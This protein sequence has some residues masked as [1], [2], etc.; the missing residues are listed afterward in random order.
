MATAFNLTAQLNVRGPTNVRSIVSSIRRQLGSISANID[1]RVD[2]AAS[3]NLTQISTALTNFN[4]TLRTTQTNAAA[5]AN[6]LRGLSNAISGINA[7]NLPRN[8]TNIATASNRAAQATGRMTAQVGQ[9]RNQMEEFGRQSAIAVRRFAAFSISSGIILGF[10]NAI[11]KG[12]RA[13]I[14]FD[15]EL[16][17][18]QQVTGESANGLSGLQ[19][20]IAGLASGLGVSSSEL[21]NV[22]STLAQAG[23]SARD[24]E[25]ALRALALSALAPSF[26][27]MNKTV[28]GSIALMKQFGISAGELDQALGSVNAVAAKFAVESSDI[29]AAIQRTGGVFASASKGVSEG[30]QALNE[31][32]AVFT[33]I[34]ATT[35][36]SA[37]TIATGLRTIFTRIQ[38]GDTIEALK[39]YGVNLTDVEGKFVGA[40]KAVELLSRGLNNI[41]PRD[42]KFSQIIEQLGGFRQIGKVIPLIQQFGTAQQ[43]LAVAQKGQGSLAED[44]AIAQLSLA[45]QISKVREEFL[46]LIRDIGGTDTFKTI[47]TS[48]LG[49][50]S[51]L[52][53][54]A[55][56]VKGVLPILGVV[57]AIKGASAISSYARGFAGGVGGG[58]GQGRGRRAAKG[59]YIQYAE[60]GG[61]PVALMP[62][63]AVVYP[64]A[65]KKIGT[66]TLRKMN[67]ADK[68][69]AK[70]GNVGVVPGSGNTDSFYTSLPAGSFVIRKKATE[71][72]GVGAINNIASGRQKFIDGETVKKLPGRGRRKPKRGP[73]E[74]SQFRA[75]PRLA[76]AGKT[77]RAHVS[78]PSALTDGSKA[79]ISNFYAHIQKAIPK[80]FQSLFNGSGGT[81]RG[82][83]IENLTLGLPKK[84]N[85]ALKRGSLTVIPLRDFLKSLDSPSLLSAVGTKLS[86]RQKKQSLPSLSGDDQQQLVKLLKREAISSST[87][88]IAPVDYLPKH[89]RVIAS[90]SQL[91]GFT[92]I[93]KDFYKSKNIS[94]NR[95]IELMNSAEKSKKK[96][97]SRGKNTGVVSSGKRSQERDFLPN[98]L[99]ENPN[100]RRFAGVEARL[101]GP[102]QKFEYGGG[103]QSFKSGTSKPIKKKRIAQQRDKDGRTREEYYANQVSRSPSKKKMTNREL[104]AREAYYANQ[105][106][107]SPSK[108]KMTNRELVAREA[109]YAKQVPGSSS[110][111]KMTNRE[112]V[113]RE[114]YYANQATRRNRLAIGGEV[115][116]Q[117]LG[118]GSGRPLSNRK[119]SNKIGRIIANLDVDQLRQSERARKAMVKSG[120]YDPK[121]DT[122]DV[123]GYRDSLAN[124][125][126]EQRKKGGVDGVDEIAAVLGSPGAGKSTLGLKGIGSKKYI[127]TAED[128]QEMIASEKRVVVRNAMA[129]LDEDKVRHLSEYDRIHMLSSTTPA[130]MKE[131]KGRLKNRT[132]QGEESVSATGIDTSTQ[133]GRKHTI[134]AQSSEDTEA[135]LRFKDEK[136][137][138]IIDERKI[139]THSIATGRR[140]GPDEV[141]TVER[142]PV[143]LVKGA[144]APPTL[145][146]HGNLF[147][148][149]DP[150]KSLLV[151]V[152]PD[153]SITEEDRQSILSGRSDAHGARS[154]LM[155]RKT[156]SKMVEK[157]IRDQGINGHV[158]TSGD[159]FVLPSMFKTGKGRYVQPDTK[160]SV[161]VIGEDR[162]ESADK[163]KQKGYKVDVVPRP[164]GGES[165]TAARARLAKGDFN[166]L[167]PSVQK[168]LMEAQQ[169][170]VFGNTQEIIPKVIQQVEKKAQIKIAA[171]DQELNKLLASVPGGRLTKDFKEKNPEATKE[172]E[173][174]R[175]RKTDTKSW[176]K[177]SGLHAL[178]GKLKRRYPERYR[179]NGDDEP[180]LMQ[181]MAD[182]GTIKP[183][184]PVTGKKLQ[185]AAIGGLVQ[186]FIKGTKNPL[187]S[188]TKKTSK[189]STK[190]PPVSVEKMGRADL[191]KKAKELG[192]YIPPFD[193][194]KLDDRAKGSAPV[195]A[196]VIA[197]LK[198]A[199]L[200]ADAK[201]DRVSQLAKNRNIAVVGLTGDKAPEE[202][203][204][205]P[206]LKGKKGKKGIR[207]F[208]ATLQTGALPDD[209]SK[210]VKAIIRNRSER[211]AVRIGNLIAARAGSSPV[212]D[213][214]KIRGIVNKQMEVMYGLFF[215]SGVAIAGAPYDPSSKAI[216]FRDGLGK[217][218][219][220][221]FGVDPKAMT[222]AT[223]Q[224]TKEVSKAKVAKG[225]FTRGGRDVRAKAKAKKLSRSKAALGGFIG[226]GKGGLAFTD[227]DMTA[228]VSKQKETPSLSGFKNPSLAVPDI[229]NA[230]PTGLL[231]LLREQ[232][233]G[234]GVLT[235]RSGGP[236]G[237]MKKALQTFFKQ[238][239]IMVP[240]NRLI[241]LG[242]QIEDVPT[243][244]KK[245]RELHRLVKKYGRFDYFDDREDIVGAAKEVKGVNARRIKVKRASGGSIPSPMNSS[246]SLNRSSKDKR[247]D[248]K[249]L[250]AFL[251]AKTSTSNKQK[252]IA[253]QL[254]DPNSSVS[255][256]PNYEEL[257]KN[258][259]GHAKGGEIPVVA[260]EGEYI[261]NRKS[262]R[263]IGYNNLHGLNKYH[264]GG[265][266]Q[267][268]GKGS[269]TPIKPAPL[270]DQGMGENRI[271]IA[272]QLMS[273]GMSAAKALAQATKMVESMGQAAKQNAENLK[274]QSK[275]VG[276]RGMNVLSGRGVD[277][278]TDGALDPAKEQ[279]YREKNR[280]SRFMR[281][282][283]RTRL[284]PESVDP[285]FV[286]PRLKGGA[287]T[288]TYSKTPSFLDKTRDEVRNREGAALRPVVNSQLADDRSSLKDTM[289]AKRDRIMAKLQDRYKS[290]STTEEKEK[291]QNRANKLPGQANR[292]L[293][294]AD[295]SLIAESQ[296]NYIQQVNDRMK[297][298][299]KAAS[300]DHIARV[301]IAKFAKQSATI[302]E[303]Q[304]TLFQKITQG[305]GKMAASAQKSLGFGGGASGGGGGG[306]IPPSGGGGGRT[307]SSKGKGKGNR[308]GPSGG[309]DNNGR[310]MGM[311]RLTQA[312]FGI[313]MMGGL[314]SQFFNPESSASN[315][316]NAA[317]TE[318]FTSTIGM[319][320]TVAGSV[321]DLMGGGGGDS[322]GRGNRRGNRGGRRNSGSRVPPV[323]GDRPS[324]RAATR[325]PSGGGGRPSKAPSGGGGGGMG[326]LGTA[327]GVLAG[328]AVFALAVAEGLKAAHNAA[329]EFAINLANTKLGESL[330]KANKAVD[331]FRN[332][333]KDKAVASD[334]KG[335]TLSAVKA[336]DTL[337]A[338]SS[339]PEAGL[340]NL[341]D[342]MSGNPG[343]FE[344]S[345]ILN[346]KG[347]VDYLST[348]SMFA[349]GE[350][351]AARNQSAQF[352]TLIPQISSERAKGYTGAAETS[353]A[354]LEAKF[355]SGSTI[356]GMQ[357]DA[358]NPD[359]FN[360]LTKS[361]ALADAAVQQQIMTVQNS[362]TLRQDEKTK[363]KNSIIAINAERKAR[364]IQTKVIRE[365]AIESLNK[366]TTMLQNSL[367]RMFQNMEQAIVSNA[368]ALDKLSA[369]A[370]LASS[371]LSGSAKV[372]SVK[373][374]SINALQNPRANSGEPMNSAVNQAAS[375][376]GNEAPAMKSMLKVASSME[377]AVMSA[378]NNTLKNNPG[379]TNEF[380]GGSIDKSIFKALS[381]L[382]LP[383]DLSAKL[384]GEV[385]LAMKE[386]RKSGED[387]VDF[388]QLVEKIPQLG[389]VLD[390]AKRAQEVAIKSLEN[391]QN[392]LNDYANTTNQLIDIQIDSNQKLRRA[393]DILVS[394]QNELANSLGKSVSLQSV[395]N[396]SRA[397]TASQTG[398][399]TDPADIRRNIQGLEATRQSEQ[400]RSDTAAQR[401]F[402]GKDEFIMMQNRL[403]NTSVALRE[404]YDA[405]KNMAENTDVASAALNKISEIKQQRQAGVGFAEKLVSST[406]KELA[407]L[408]MSMA[409]LQNNMAGGMNASNAG[410]RA[411]DL[412][413]FNELAPLLGDKQSGMKA[414]VLESMLKE[415]GVGVSPMMQDVLDS[416]RNPEGDPAM[417][418]AIGIY[419]EAV[420]L[421]AEANK[422]LVRLNNQMAE[423]SADIAGQKLAKSMTGVILKFESQQLLDINANITTLI[424]AVKAKG[425]LVPGAAPGA[426]PAKGIARGGMIYAAAGQLVDFAPKGTDT[427]PAMLTPGEF[428]VNRKSTQ[429]HLPLLKS[430]NNSKTY[431]KGGKAGY[432]AT[433]GLVFAAPWQREDKEDALD[434]SNSQ[435]NET[436]DRYPDL[437]KDGRTKGDLSG[438]FEK[439][440]S[441]EGSF[442]ATNKN[443]G[444]VT[445]WFFN[446]FNGSYTGLDPQATLGSSYGKLTAAVGGGRSNNVKTSEKNGPVDTPLIGTI[447]HLAFFSAVA[448]E[449]EQV[450]I[451]STDI[452]DYNT[453]LDVLLP[454][455]PATDISGDGV[456]VEGKNIIL[457]SILDPKSRP[458]LSPTVKVTG[459]ADRY[460]K[461]KQ[462]ITI[463]NLNKKTSNLHGLYS[464][465]NLDTIKANSNDAGGIGNIYGVQQDLSDTAMLL[466]TVGDFFFGMPTSLRVMKTSPNMLGGAQQGDQS[467][468]I[469]AGL[470]YMQN[471][472]GFY[473]I[474]LDSDL[475]STTRNYGAG[476][477]GADIENMKLRLDKTKH[478]KETLEKAKQDMSGQDVKFEESATSVGNRNY[479][480]KLQQLLN[481]SV[482]KA[483]FSEDEIQGKDPAKPPVTLY[484]LGGP[485][486]DTR[487]DTLNNNPAVPKGTYA[488]K[489][490]GPS[491]IGVGS[492]TT[493]GGHTQFKAD[494]Y[495]PWVSS[496]FNSTI[497]D[498]LKQK[499]EAQNQNNIKVTPGSYTDDN[500]AFNYNQIE[501]SMFDA[502]KKKTKDKYSFTT[503]SLGDNLLNEK[504]NPFQDLVSQKML[505][506]AP[507]KTHIY[508]D[509][510]QAIID[511]LN[512]SMAQIINGGNTL[513][514]GTSI[515]ALD[516]A[517]PAISKLDFN[518][519]TKHNAYLANSRAPG[520]QYEAK[521][522]G[523]E[524]RKKIAAKKADKDGIAGE[525]GIPNKAKIL[526]LSE[527]PLLLVKQAQDVISKVIAP[528]ANTL[529]GY[530]IRL[531]PI[532]TAEQISPYGNYLLK[533][534]KFFGNSVNQK[535]KNK[536]RKNGQLD[537]PPALWNV[538][539]A[540]G[541]TGQVFEKLGKGDKQGLE[542]LLGSA[543]GVFGNNDLAKLTRSYAYL[544]ASKGS[545]FA[546]TDQSLR[547]EITGDNDKQTI[548]DIFKKKTTE[549]AMVTKGGNLTVNKNDGRNLPTTL[550]DLGKKIVNPYST[551]EPA[552]RGALFD[553]LIQ[554]LN[555]FNNKGQQYSVND[556]LSD[557]LA[558]LK[559]FYGS[560]LDPIVTGGVV[561]T[562]KMT[563]EISQQYEN[564][565]TTLQELTN[566][567]FGMMPD[568]NKMVELAAAKKARM[569]AENKSRGGVIYAQNGTLVD[570]QP[571]GTDTVPAMLTPGEFVV[572]KASTAKHLPL[573]QSINRNSGGMA[574]LAEG[575]VATTS[576][577]APKSQKIPTS[578]KETTGYMSTLALAAEKLVTRSVAALQSASES[579]DAYLFNNNIGKAIQYAVPAIKEGALQAESALYGMA[580]SIV[581]TAVGVGV[582]AV[583][584]P[585]VTPVGG[586]AAGL[587]AGIASSAAQ[588]NYLN[589]LFPEINAYMNRRM[590]DRPIA[591]IAGAAIGG[592]TTR[593]ATNVSKSITPIL[594]GTFSETVANRAAE[595]VK[596]I[597]QLGKGT[598]PERA[599]GAATAAGGSVAVD[600]ASVSWSGDQIDFGDVLTRAARE[601]VVGSLIPAN[602]PVTMGRTS[603]T[604]GASMTQEQ[605]AYLGQKLSGQQLLT[606]VSKKMSRPEGSTY[607]PKTATLNEV[608]AAAQTKAAAMKKAIEP[609]GTGKIRPELPPPPKPLS[610][611]SKPLSPL[612]GTTQ[613]WIS[614][615]NT[616]VASLGSVAP[617]TT[618]L[619]RIGS[620]PKDYVPPK[621]ANLFGEQMPLAE[622]KKKMAVMSQQ[623][624]G[625]DAGEAAGKWFTD[626]HKELD[627]YIKENNDKL[628]TLDAYY[629]DVLTK[630]LH[631]FS[632]SPTGGMK[633][634]GLLS[635]NSEREFVLPQADQATNIGNLVRS[636]GLDPDPTIFKKIPDKR[637]AKTVSLFHA[638]NTGFEDSALKSFQTE[639]GKSGIAEG[640]GQGKGLYNF[641]SR[642]AA[643]KHAQSIMR[644]DVQTRADTRGKPMIVKFDEALDPSKFDLDYELNAG[645]VTKWLYDHYDDVQKILSDQKTPMLLQRRMDP[646]AID[647]EAQKGIRTSVPDGLEQTATGLPPR[648]WIYGSQKD[649]ST[650]DGEILSKIMSAVGK[651]DPKLLS[652]F[653]EGFFETMPPGS[654]I[655]YIG[656]D[657]LAPSNIDVLSKARGG[658]IYASQGARGYQQG[659]VVYAQDGKK[660]DRASSIIANEPKALK[661]YLS[662]K[663]KQLGIPSDIESVVNY[664]RKYNMKELER[665]AKKYPDIQKELNNRSFAQS[666]AQSSPFQTGGMIYASEGKLINFQPRG[667]DTVPAMLTPGEF[668]VNKASTQKNLPLLKAINNGAKN[669]KALSKGGIAYL[670]DGGFADLK[671]GFADLGAYT[672]ND[673][674]IEQGKAYALEIANHAK[675]TAEGKAKSQKC[676]DELG[677]KEKDKTSNRLKFMNS[678]EY[679]SSVSEAKQANT[680]ALSRRNALSIEIAKLQADF[681][682][683][684]KTDLAKVKEQTGLK[685]NEQVFAQF[686]R[687]AIENEFTKPKGNIWSNIEFNGDDL[688]AF[689]DRIAQLVNR[690]ISY[691]QDSVIKENDGA[692]YRN[693]F[694]IKPAL[695][696]NVG[697]R[698]FDAPA[699]AGPFERRD[700]PIVRGL[701]SRTKREM[702]EAGNACR[703]KHETQIPWELKQ[704][705]GNKIAASTL[706]RGGMIYASQGTLVNYQPRGTDTVPA[707]L[708]PGEFVINKQ[709]TQR[710]LPLLKSI[711]S[712]RYQNGGIIQPQYHA[713]GDVSSRM[714]K[715]A[716]AVAGVVGIKLDTGKIEEQIN[717][718]M[719][720]GA[721]LLAGAIGFS[722]SDLSALTAFG[723]SLQTFLSQMSQINIPPEIK[724]SMAPVQVNITGAQG[725]T[726]AAQGLVDGAIKKAFDGF[727]SVNNLQGTYKSP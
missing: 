243:P 417:Q 652:K 54:V 157:T 609:V 413:L 484:N 57:M 692:Y 489:E 523:D 635:A 534:Q 66:P 120:F 219:G 204:V 359:E 218:L 140:K 633:K 356:E 694:D 86:S 272:K 228:A 547:K 196:R 432:Y 195:R 165:G 274:K 574:Y 74:E 662:L 713:D 293:A 125:A 560:Y 438:Y 347:M 115:E 370:D 146:G 173:K 35:R 70:G 411:G 37:E 280:D 569:E 361:L 708:T 508:A 168:M 107:R 573:L 522:Y 181:Q 509:N 98:D 42:L 524:L 502:N 267:K 299:V 666:S 499:Y 495:F 318:S 340:L 357:K 184:R 31:F 210:K 114:A 518:D 676:K 617:D 538:W 44:A 619:Y 527:N 697:D 403:K 177:R 111:K 375:M 670:Q 515:K 390:S 533:A 458:D 193:R 551:F 589:Y 257:L 273:Q 314:G 469:V 482:F 50:A 430:I 13:F 106:S 422:Q 472:G 232:Y 412:Q 593:A 321:G 584:S 244:E 4:T 727:L 603:I 237:E 225:Q 496:G 242:D 536:K 602:S 604:S 710:N 557:K 118:G 404:N 610:N 717:S 315:A 152:G 678:D 463:S 236:K 563:N 396:D 222:D 654:A 553:I 51:A 230:S 30:T 245:A 284:A 103:V 166:G 688:P 49:L 511:N 258:L 354:F 381:D 483:T 262:A 716:G 383:P 344:R 552:D 211:I 414:N 73:A 302:A 142:K 171:I 464:Q 3:R 353:T 160:N 176:A 81:R 55:D 255:G 72:M 639:G 156:R 47:A 85:E 90:D 568:A 452:K 493:V 530:N 309:E 100:L 149:G 418:E 658:M 525:K 408:N 212:T 701:R 660:I 498:D 169:R 386:M 18:L 368:Y 640:Y 24:T 576:P 283:D 416:L 45:N 448:A 669:P 531:S 607:L 351:N 317:F 718:A 571:R 423:N 449:S 395:V 143:R 586:F 683:Q 259:K 119:R 512:Q 460:G 614:D 310:M 433:G 466:E 565:N 521:L 581:P 214:E 707:M 636:V 137:K 519:V 167:S 478:L 725:L 19:K 577:T 261:I 260:Q 192:V 520:F 319:G 29:I 711:N 681:V 162:I 275:S 182:R 163:Y 583:A 488:D 130:E 312:G 391:W 67:Y 43:A 213:K 363:L 623:T 215:E 450:K 392:A 406:P 28:E 9:A 229:M 268:F 424:T 330:E 342:A 175:G 58:G 311:G 92:K 598:L 285:S 1:L 249:K 205:N 663:S 327:G 371:S 240:D 504:L 620:V 350:K 122:Y 352:S 674:E 532:R 513:S 33:S 178:M 209:V 97:R 675:K 105:A 647:R 721:K 14:D 87:R 706:Q 127:E 665:V 562:K 348:T 535:F 7:N 693:M 179:I 216:D 667:T 501:G 400:A 380:V 94:L 425:G 526:G 110:K 642:E 641:T 62:G 471:A 446:K 207:G 599:V 528:V 287:T 227:F 99:S 104:V 624:K 398:G 440:F 56:S 313:S 297:M 63:E 220:D 251:G 723:T 671:Q 439:L 194:P 715:A 540:L 691:G 48:A 301:R 68:K 246:S 270:S 600:L 124:V 367:E 643:E 158:S 217:K 26:D 187:E 238:N 365:M 605:L 516:P 661:S 487:V 431:S 575:G 382:K 131:L 709:A 79:L 134:K 366:S 32:I 291:L 474:G 539:G 170:N 201:S 399:P 393:T 148:H 20:T 233:G 572:N 677:Q 653:R 221:M 475:A 38:R 447:P 336:A 689:Q 61:V 389:K 566:G 702:T 429:Q 235:A 298:A 248:P 320:A 150:K 362:N 231:K 453:A 588:E 65:A 405:L 659:G 510:P 17:K 304:P 579:T 83:L 151:N 500:M 239:G 700:M 266:V 161:A 470:D 631:K 8:M 492:K 265:V 113:A 183:I 324:P 153:E 427:V 203:V 76:D 704:N 582:G 190:K 112:L 473:N 256:K 726:D 558:N 545:I 445:P 648:K 632:V 682:K 459:K 346:K 80:K 331:K 618:R 638:S 147:S 615:F 720:N 685:T 544:L 444:P 264:S 133:F 145:K 64:A 655:K 307:G 485:D 630:D 462:F 714:S 608:I 286:G 407:N 208:P 102:I 290:S 435:E 476:M 616:V 664:L 77:V 337:A 695:S 491:W 96:K 128:I 680:E 332:N 202:E 135:M 457:D 41:D 189:S 606:G 625:V 374:D 306:F 601:A 59:G 410:Q 637:A 455:L 549:E 698:K 719:S 467:T 585:V 136:G 712:H 378:I 570:Y 138:Q 628:Q 16:V 250:A 634:Y 271:Q 276:Y 626:D 434:R 295:K 15:K 514:F 141:P 338:A 121:K 108:K 437:L 39:E 397:K 548:E 415:S 339:K 517:D 441:V 454:K 180:S 129:S 679:K 335:A 673:D 387:N 241:T 34:R 591:S 155:D 198:A 254:K 46:T 360:N 376:F 651:R 373:L 394:G 590:N 199:G 109:Y 421:Q 529:S 40:Y 436:T 88:L 206:N 384:S 480:N 22:S 305:I 93:I 349:G 52:I 385:G 253:D 426:A 316:A 627:F 369:S 289:R 687:L 343:S 497:F 223:S 621:T 419:K 613:K 481:G 629:V 596:R 506:Q 60:G 543:A 542:T 53:K 649:Y 277:I 71:S 364:E 468:R 379:A 172:I 123:P 645:Y 578:P 686:P 477:F 69:M 507:E 705:T 561:P 401:G 646:G 197:E 328:V 78:K 597:P 91:Y 25:K 224:A 345:Q 200:I 226:L 252:E 308:R 722:S 442:Y 174:L 595:I 587:T 329:R 281:R 696:T 724:F 703:E 402:G 656:S 322:G 594:G 288:R 36:E 101:G 465:T 185:R 668:V 6:A 23:L 456:K 358:T 503:V 278:T 622:W 612:G 428:V 657:N 282:G 341:G 644:G 699:W 559:K 139:A 279:R 684:L 580:K 300:D 144:F 377:D 323:G 326:M 611:I 95:P 486:W 21:I 75:A 372:G 555:K 191:L 505:S 186:K 541:A 443:G 2:P 247:F 117:R 550:L 10:T 451:K 292:A 89:S 672:P 490:H 650:L 556:Q 126:L 494:K 690:M 154:L 234:V 116:A 132:R 479:I 564:M 84:Y 5:T 388:S 269:K 325:A 294:K 164:E 333:L 537:I 303:Q 546:N 461:N 82:E 567:E 12:A 296:K 334:A 27:D 159:G 11:T 420:G 263:A 554:G 409:R 592:G 355:R 188:L